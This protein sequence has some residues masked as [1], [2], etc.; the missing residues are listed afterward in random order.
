MTDPNL[1]LSFKKRI[2]IMSWVNGVQ[3]VSGISA[4]DLRKL[5]ACDL[6]EIPHRTT[7]A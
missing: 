2:V 4:D 5:Q 1:S 7:A 6:D 3:M